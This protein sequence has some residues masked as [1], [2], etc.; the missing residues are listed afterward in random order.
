M[1]DLQNHP[2]D[3]QKTLIFEPSRGPAAELQE[4]VLQLVESLAQS[5]HQLKEDWSSLSLGA[6]LRGMEEEEWPD[7]T[8]PQL[9]EAGR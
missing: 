5:Q 3:F 1:S 6:A 2:L 4:Q 7:H 9:V 8:D